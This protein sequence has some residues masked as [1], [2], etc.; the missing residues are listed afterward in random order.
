MKYHFHV[1]ANNPHPTSAARVVTLSAKP[2]GDNPS[3]GKGKPSADMRMTIH[4]EAEAKKYVV[5]ED[6]DI[7]VTPTKPA[8][9]GV[10]TT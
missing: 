1:V 10:S 8:G 3:L 9:T 5:G 6:Y 4:D 7:T 2:K